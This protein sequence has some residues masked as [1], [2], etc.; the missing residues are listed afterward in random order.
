M[1]RALLKDGR[2]IELVKDCGC[3]THD[4]PH[5]LHM[6]NLCKELNA[7]HKR[8]ETL[9]PKGFVVEERARLQNL[10]YQMESR[11]IVRLIRDPEPKGG[12]A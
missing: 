4:G 12:V 8:P 2:E 10:L 7:Q 1:A 3:V 6:D 5:W 9:S 11:S